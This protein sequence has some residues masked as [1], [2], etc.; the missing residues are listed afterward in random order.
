MNPLWILAWSLQCRSQII[1]LIFEK[2]HIIESRLHLVNSKLL[3]K[4]RQDL[5]TFLLSVSL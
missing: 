3:A 2:N 4:R 1:G 5:F